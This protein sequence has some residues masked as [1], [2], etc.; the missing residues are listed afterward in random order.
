[1]D[2]QR[3]DPAAEDSCYQ[4]HVTGRQQDS[5]WD[6]PPMSAGL[7]SGYLTCGWMGEPQETWLARMPSGRVAGWYQLELPDLENQHRASVRVTVD[8]ALRRQGTGRALLRHAQDRACRTR[9]DRTVRLRLAWVA[10]RGVRP[11][12]RR[13][14]RALDHTSCARPARARPSGLY[15]GGVHA[16]VVVRPD[17]RGGPR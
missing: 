13:G 17:T 4:V 16:G 1:M 6:S 9:K 8:P 10:R 7:F 14:T 11:V 2:I 5:P 12:G 15:P 3:L